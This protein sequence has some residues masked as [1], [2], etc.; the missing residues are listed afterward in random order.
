MKDYEPT[1]TKGTHSMSIVW[2]ILIGIVAGWL[3]G[4]IMEGGQ[5]GALGNLILG[6]IGSL[7]GGFIFALLGITAGGLL[8]ELT[9]ATVGAVVLIAVARAIRR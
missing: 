3:A 4:R 7:V 2:F 5:S 8:G 6:V 9:M 1:H